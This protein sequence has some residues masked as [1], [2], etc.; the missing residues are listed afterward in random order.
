M[1]AKRIISCLDVKGGRV[2]KGTHFLNLRDAG[3]PVELGRRYSEEGADEL[4][5][6]DITANV[7]KRTTLTQ[8]VRGVASELDIPFTVGGGINTMEEARVVLLNGADKTSVNTAAVRH[9]AL[10]TEIAD[11]F[12]AQCCVIAVDAK[13]NYEAKPGATTIDTPQ[14]RCW[15]EVYVSGGRAATGIDA[16]RWV[17][18]ATALGAGEVLLTS[19][20]CDGTKNGYDLPLTSAV[21]RAV[22]VPVVTSGGAGE[23]RHFKEAFDAGADAA[24]AASVFHYGNHPIPEVKQYLKKMGVEI[25]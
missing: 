7:E 17:K 15:F 23:P 18:E 24:L 4:V 2:V 21:A 16:L 10:I 22:N 9:P 13:R 19:M 25:R 8:L 11:T 5:F 20:D 3:D 6:L 14:G 1:L 12:G